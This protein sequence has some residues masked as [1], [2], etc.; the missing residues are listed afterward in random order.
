[1]R[2]SA[3]TRIVLFIGTRG[4]SVG[5]EE[6]VVSLSKR[7][8]RSSRYSSSLRRPSAFAVAS[9]FSRW[10]SVIV[11]TSADE[12]G[13]V[14]SSTRSSCCGRDADVEVPAQCES[15][16]T[17]GLEVENDCFST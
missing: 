2:K 5:T 13:L 4:V 10:A 15:F 14:A 7:F 12:R 9:S 6:P 3:F 1:M 16:E 8:W 11:R 17:R